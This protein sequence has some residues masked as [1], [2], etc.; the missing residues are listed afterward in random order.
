[1]TEPKYCGKCGCYIPDGWNRCPACNHVN[2]S[3]AETTTNAWQWYGVVGTVVDLRERG[4]ISSEVYAQC[5]KDM[6]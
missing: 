5:L 4:I 2:S 6:M 1:M 3:E